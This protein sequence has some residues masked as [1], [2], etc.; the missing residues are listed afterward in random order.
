MAKQKKAP[1]AAT[2]TGLLDS[3][4]TRISDGAARG[5]ANA[6][7]IIGLDTKIDNV[8]RNSAAGFVEQNKAIADN[9]TGTTYA[10]ES[11]KTSTQ[12]ALDGVSSDIKA[13]HDCAQRHNARIS[14]VEGANKNMDERLASLYR[15]VS[16][17]EIPTT[18]TSTTSQ[19]EVELKALL[20]RFGFDVYQVGV[21]KTIHTPPLYMASGLNSL[22]NAG[23][24]QSRGSESISIEIVGTKAL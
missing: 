10:L 1:V 20:K 2:L 4:Q 13:A 9:A 24:L 14:L 21:K 15:R 22:H 12:R 16:T 17:L 11:L 6:D 19:L 7:E 18:S 3:M 23:S 5:A 8:T